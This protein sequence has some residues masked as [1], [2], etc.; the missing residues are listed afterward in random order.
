[1]LLV[2][3]LVVL[4]LAAARPQRTV[5]VSSNSTTIMLAL[6][7][8]GSMCSTDVE[9]NRIDAA[10]KAATNFINAQ[11]HGTRIGLVAFAGVAARTRA[12]DH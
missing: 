4:G 9:P 7:V 1:M 10:E 5:A 12:A 6:D 8:S 11:P 2:L 3:G